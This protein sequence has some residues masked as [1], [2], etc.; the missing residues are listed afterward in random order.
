MYTI[1][2]NTITC[3]LG[4]LEIERFKQLR[5]KAYY[6]MLRSFAECQKN[7]AKAEHQ[8]WAK[9]SQHDQIWEE[10]FQDSLGLKNKQTKQGKVIADEKEEEREEIVEEMKRKENAVAKKKSEEEK[11]SQ[12]VES[13]SKE[14]LTKEQKQL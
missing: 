4:N 9:A 2:S 7:L 1:L 12:I 14:E 6:Q 10:G 8:I 11:L 5:Q 13:A 3:L